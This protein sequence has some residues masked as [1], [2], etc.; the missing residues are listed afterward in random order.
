MTTVVVV[1][2][3][4][5]I[6]IAADS[7]STFGDTRLSA[8]MDA[9]WDK[10]FES[11]GG[12]FSISGSAAHDLV[13]QAALKKNPKLSFASRPAIFE[14]F[15]KLHPKLKEEFFMKPDEEEDDPYESSQ[16][17]ALLANPNG[18]FG[19]YSLRE[20]YEYER[21]WAI[22]SGADYALGAMQAVYD[23]PKLS[24]ADIARAG[25]EAGCVFDVN[26]SLPMTLYTTSAARR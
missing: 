8:S 14:S 18:I 23:N 16:I 5:E 11:H 22:G 10:I 24:A 20:V 6:A 9:R 1:R 13:L 25:V 7:Q 26:S 2:K 17:T 4:N 21:F 3:K 19:V 15:R 12:Y